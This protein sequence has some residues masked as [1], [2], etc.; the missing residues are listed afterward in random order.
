MK[1]CSKKTVYVCDFQLYA[2]LR[3]RSGW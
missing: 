3:W 2:V 1:Y